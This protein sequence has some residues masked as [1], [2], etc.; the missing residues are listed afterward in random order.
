MHLVSKNVFKNFLFAFHYCVEE[1]LI[2]ILTERLSVHNPASVT[3]LVFNICYLH[4]A[5]STTNPFRLQRKCSHSP[6][7]CPE[8]NMMNFCGLNKI[9]CSCGVTLT[10]FLVSSPLVQSPSFLVLLGSDVITELRL[11]LDF[12]PPE[13]TFF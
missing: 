2:L 8:S 13:K 5:K 1:Y 7:C 3:I 6:K 11:V 4:P 12:R 10:S 9:I